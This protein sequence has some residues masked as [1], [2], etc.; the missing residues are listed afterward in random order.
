VVNWRGDIF[1]CCIAFKDAPAPQRTGNVADFPS[2]FQAWCSPEMT[3]W[4]RSVF[5]V[6]EK[7]GPCRSCRGHADYVEAAGAGLAEYVQA[8]IGAES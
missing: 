1:M 6:G 3:A 5:A 4:R 2:I 7:S 8:R